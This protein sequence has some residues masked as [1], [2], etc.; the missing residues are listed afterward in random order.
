MLVAAAT[1][2]ATAMAMSGGAAVASPD[3][4]SSMFHHDTMHTGVSPDTVIGAAHAPALSVRWSLPVGG[5]PVYASP[6]V[7]YNATK[8]MALVY[9]VSVNG[10]VRASTIAGTPVW[11]SQ[12]S[13]GSGVVDS[14]AVDGNSLYIGSDNGVLTALDATTGAVQCSYQLP[15]FAPENVPG[16]IESS[17]VV[18]HD[19]TGPIVYFGDAGQSE[20]VGRGREWAMN[21]VGNTAG[22][23]TVRWMHDLGKP[24]SKR[25]GSWSPPALGN[26]STGRPLVVFGTS[27]SDAAVYAL[28]AR[29]GSLVW[30]FQTL[31][32][33]SDADVG[34]GPTI[35]APGVNGIQDGV[36]YVEGKD[37]IMYAIDMR[38]GKQRWSFDLQAD[39]DHSSKA[40]SCAALV[41][42]MVV[43]TY[44]KYVYAFN[45]VTG[46]EVWRSAAGAGNTLG[47][48][49]VSGG[50]GDQVVLRGD[51]DGREY[52]YAV[53]NGSL[54]A[55]IKVAHTAFYSSTAVADGM[56]FIAGTDG[57]LYALG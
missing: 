2:A 26:D 43:V 22:A 38:T 5:G 31:R 33:F 28:D 17:P 54:L 52:A 39:T 7:V 41:G 55:T 30:R 29:D 20:S 8:A 6:A 51:L 36:V 3:D 18:G 48:V 12:H 57:L 42:K 19:S 37:R 46:A 27:Q 21:G 15:I 25:I 50:R 53:S 40:V 44:W 14:P 24:G 11:T 1:I 47:S 16:R 13:V 10:I 49:S 23:C 9:E 45:A 35:S 34:A 32:T 56:A 4:D